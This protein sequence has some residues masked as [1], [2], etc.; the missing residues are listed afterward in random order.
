M[1]KD[2]LYLYGFASGPLSTKAQFFKKKFHQKANFLI[3]DYIPDKESFTNLQTSTL[4][5]DMHIFIQRKYPEKIILFGSSFGGLLSLWYSI[6]HPEKISKLILMAPALKFSA[7]V[8]AEL[9]EITPVKWKEF[10]FVTVPHYRYNQEVLLSFSF[11]NDIL[12]NP[13]PNFYKQDLSI[14]G[15]IFHGE[16]DEVVP[17][18]WSREFAEV[19][20]SVIL[21]ELKS[22]HQ[23]LDQKEKMW[24]IID[25]FL[26]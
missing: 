22:H 17:I 2:I 10:G 18:S 5:K 15:L 20:S 25:K 9:L 21:H 16:F 8:I 26:K 14:P 19:N 4:L 13:P 12:R 6:L 3:Y 23:L 1:K 11:Y 24:T 7:D